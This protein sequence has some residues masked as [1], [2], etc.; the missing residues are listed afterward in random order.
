MKFWD[1]CASEALIQAMMGV[2]C[3]ADGKPIYY[4]PDGITTEDHTV[5]SGIIVAKNKRVYDTMN[6]RL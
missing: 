3:S 2:C 1:M 4:S 5:L 6:E